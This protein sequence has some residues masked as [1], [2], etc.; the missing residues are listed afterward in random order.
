MRYFVSLD[1]TAVPNVVDVIELPTG[2]LDV[3][4]DLLHTRVVNV[5]EE[6]EFVRHKKTILANFAQLVLNTGETPASAEET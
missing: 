1:P 6:D 3:S 5:L 2:E 4:I